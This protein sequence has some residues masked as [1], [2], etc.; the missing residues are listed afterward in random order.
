MTVMDFSD[1][2]KKLSDAQWRINFNLFVHHVHM[3]IEP[4][5]R[6]KLLGDEQR[7]IELRDGRVNRALTELAETDEKLQ[8]SREE[9]TVVVG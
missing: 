5:L 7:R 1:H 6:E 4:G 9:T 2:A 3:R 8:M